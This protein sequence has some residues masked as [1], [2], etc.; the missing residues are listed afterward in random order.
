MLHETIVAKLI[1]LH[2]WVVRMIR[3][4]YEGAVECH[5]HA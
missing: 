5:P 4:M 1:M 2:E 3:E